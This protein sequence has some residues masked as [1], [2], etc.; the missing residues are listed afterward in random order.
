MTVPIGGGSPATLLRTLYPGLTGPGAIAIDSTNLYVG[1]MA[2]SMDAGYV[3]TLMKIPLDGGTPVIL[4]TGDL[5]TGDPQYIAVDATTV[6][7]TNTG[8]LQVPANGSVMSVP[9]DGGTPTV[10][11]AGEVQPSGIAVDSTSVYW[12]SATGL[13]KRT[14]K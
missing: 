12:G 11:S 14:P 3:G 6:Y 4:A 2:P 9:I 10:L 7:W 8:A 1:A 5:T 13:W